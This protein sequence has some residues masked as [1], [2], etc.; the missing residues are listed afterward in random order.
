MS[1]SSQIVVWQVP[2]PPPHPRN[3]TRFTEARIHGYATEEMGG[4]GIC[5]LRR[6]TIHVPSITFFVIVKTSFQ[7][8]V[9][10][11]I[12]DRWSTCRVLALLP[13]DKLSFQ[14]HRRLLVV[15]KPNTCKIEWEMSAKRPIM[16]SYLLE[17]AVRCPLPFWD[18]PP[19]VCFR[20]GEDTQ[21]ARFLKLL[22][23]KKQNTLWRHNGSQR[24][25]ILFIQKWL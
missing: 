8:G 11:I 13:P 5:D 22:G 24:R 6:R 25:Y 3:N 16:A 20:R 9:V 15:I 14:I 2:N 10:F 4:G 21:S 1:S 23:A 7:K 12:S 17:I 19:K 18:M